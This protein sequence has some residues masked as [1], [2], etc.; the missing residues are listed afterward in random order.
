[1]Q[2]TFDSVSDLAAALR[3][4]DYVVIVLSGRTREPSAANARS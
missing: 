3:R 4:A 2:T 1:M